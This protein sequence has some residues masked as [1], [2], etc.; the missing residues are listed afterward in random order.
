VFI[1]PVGDLEQFYKV[2][3]SHGTKWINEV[4]EIDLKNSTELKAARE[5]VEE[6]I[7]Y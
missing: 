3:A 6:I 2:S 1:V 5:F 7:K 4:L